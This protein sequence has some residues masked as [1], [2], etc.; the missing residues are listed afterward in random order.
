MDIL[1]ATI[2]D[3]GNLRRVEK[4]CFPLDA[5]PLLD[6]IA[7]LTWPDVVRLK[8]VIKGEMIGFIA[9]DP[10]PSENTSWIAV[11][12]VMPDYR[13]LGIARR[14]LAMCEEKLPTTRIRLCV[15]TGNE[16]AIQLY[17]S[18]GYR[19][20]D[21]WQKYYNDGGNALVMEKLRSHQ[22]VIMA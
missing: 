12:G 22:I 4:I 17:E 21:I 3:L 14:M 9:G 20:L 1:P 18:S 10:R 11:L 8:A 19:R 7:V 16:A 2:R 5:W 15:R 13:R 6:L